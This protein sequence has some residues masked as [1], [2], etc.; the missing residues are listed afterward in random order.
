MFYPMAS[1]LFWSGATRKCLERSVLKAVTVEVVRIHPQGVRAKRLVQPWPAWGV[2]VWKHTRP[3]PI[4]LG[5]RSKIFGG[6]KL[7]HERP[8][9]ACR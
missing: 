2:R 5:V 1:L 3:G 4:S 8:E 9:R 7:N 6:E